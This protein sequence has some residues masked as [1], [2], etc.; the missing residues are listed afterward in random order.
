[1]ALGINQDLGQL[2]HV[3]RAVSRQLEPVLGVLRDGKAIEWGCLDT[4][5]SCRQMLTHIRL[6]AGDGNIVTR[7]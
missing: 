7:H 1:M 6:G 5:A 2:I 3:V 4:L